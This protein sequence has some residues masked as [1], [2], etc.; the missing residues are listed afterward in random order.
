MLARSVKSEGQRPEGP[1]YRL[2]TFGYIGRNRRLDAVLKALAELPE[3]DQLQLDVYGNILDEE[4]QLRAR[5]R[6]LDLK[7]QVTLHGFAPEAKL[8]H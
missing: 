4:K 3:R 7:K 2:I 8:F 5:I 6:S 1:P